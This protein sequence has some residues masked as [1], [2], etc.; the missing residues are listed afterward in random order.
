MDDFEAFR[1]KKLAEKRKGGSSLYEFKVEEEGKAKIISHRQ[2]LK[3][4][5]KDD[6]PEVKGFDSHI[7]RSNID[8]ESIGKFG[9]KKL[10]GDDISKVDPDSVDKLKGITSHIARTKKPDPD[11]LDKPSGLK[12]Y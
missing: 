5:P 8:P 10:W 6:I 9:A 7:S 2:K 12:R 3:E 11:S 1:K 4:L